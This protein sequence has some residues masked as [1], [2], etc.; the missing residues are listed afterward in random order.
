LSLGSR[1]LLGLGSGGSSGPWVG[2]REGSLEDPKG[3]E[4]GALED[5]IE[6]PRE[7]LVGAS[8][9]W[10]SGGVSETAIEGVLAGLAGSYRLWTSLS[11]SLSSLL[12]VILEPAGLVEAALDP[13][14]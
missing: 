5:H 3:S 14:D 6:D 11:N 2:S 10:A 13:K 7:S 9:S 12:R 8:G 1:A 4:D